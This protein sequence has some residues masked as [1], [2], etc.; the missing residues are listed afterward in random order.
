MPPGPLHSCVT[1]S[2]SLASHLITDHLPETET[3]SYPT[4]VELKEMKK[5][6]KLICLH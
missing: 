3:V 6:K 2:L 1:G 4:D 5:Y